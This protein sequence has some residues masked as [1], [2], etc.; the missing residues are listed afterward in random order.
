[1]ILFLFLLHT[2]IPTLTYGIAGHL[3]IKHHKDLYINVLRRK[4]SSGSDYD[5][6]Q[7]EKICM[8]R[9]YFLNK[10]DINSPH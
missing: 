6:D 2:G 7:V 5:D 10:E 8:V 9:I 4:S 1:M 3:L